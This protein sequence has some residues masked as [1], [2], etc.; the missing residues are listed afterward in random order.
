MSFARAIWRVL[1]SAVAWVVAAPF[2]SWSELGPLAGQPGRALVLGRVRNNPHSSELASYISDF[3]SVVWW[4]RSYLIMLRGLMLVA[5]IAIPTLTVVFVRSEVQPIWLI[6]TV[7]IVILWAAV[8]VQTQ[9]ILFH[10]VARIVDR[11]LGTREEF[12]TGIEITDRPSVNSMSAHQLRIATSRLRDISPTDAI[13]WRWPMGDLKVVIAVAAI[14]G[15]IVVSSLL[16]VQVPLVSPPLEEELLT[17]PLDLADEYFELMPGDLAALDYEEFMMGGAALPF[18]D[19]EMA[20]QFSL[21]STSNDFLLQ[22]AEIEK[23]LL[24][25]A[26]LSSNSQRGLS[27]LA[28]SLSDSSVMREVA[29]SINLGDF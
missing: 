21:D 22:L 2:S 9:G 15:L 12:A 10:D 4:R 23:M 1:T 24:A 8:V 13:G 25:Q 18:L 17:D 19:D 3:H 6:P 26:E 11:N 27:E 20:A 16:G 29:T 28:S 7:A 5:L 14:S